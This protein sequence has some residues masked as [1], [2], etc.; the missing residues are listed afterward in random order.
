FYAHN[1]VFRNSTTLSTGYNAFGQLGYVENGGQLA[2]RTVPG[3]LNAFFPFAGVAQGGVHSVAFFNNST[4]RCWGYNGF[5]QLGNKT[6]TFSGTPIKTVDISGVK[7]VA[8]GGFHTLAL[9]N[10]DTLWAWGKNDLGQL[11][12]GSGVTD[13]IFKVGYSTIPVKVFSGTVSGGFSNIS[14]IAAN[15]HHSLA[16]ANGLVWSWGLNSSGQLGIDPATTGA[17]SAPNVVSGL[18]ASGVSA[19]AAGGGFNYALGKDKTVW[20]WGSNSNGQLGDGTTTQSF[21]PVQV[22][23]APGVPLSNVVQ[24]AAGIQHGLARLADNT[25]WAWGYNF[26]NQLG[27]NQKSDSPFAVQVVL[28]LSTTPLKDATD[29]RAFGSSSMAKVGKVWYVWG[30]NTYGQLGTC[31]VGIVPIPVI[32]G[33]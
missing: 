5:G 23:T 20:A 11:G 13:E 25:V 4:V 8:A 27:N 19:V 2:N 14:S 6:T 30:D 17:M 28:G 3:P 31:S 18:P 26:F 16:R 21:K 24:I 1:L 10:D 9:K 15:G 29:I 12:V 32:S 33:F 7:A 22:Q